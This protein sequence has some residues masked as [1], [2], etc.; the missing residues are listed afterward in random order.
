MPPI[1]NLD[2]LTAALLLAKNTY[3]LN[4]AKMCE[5][6]HR[7]E[8]AH[9]QSDQWLK[10]SSPGME[11]I[12]GSLPPNY[13]WNYLA[14]FWLANPQYKPI[15]IWSAVDND[16]ALSASTGKQG[17][18]IFPSIEASIMS[19]CHHIQCDDGGNWGGWFS[20]IGIEQAKYTQ[21]LMTI[22][23]RICNTFTV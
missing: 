12:K 15:G 6:L 4:A 18:I 8:T 17:F 21:V 5:C 20:T 16:S 10:C 2:K 13:G 9:F 11:M 19:V 14:N 23:P 22:I 7:N 1:A 3:S